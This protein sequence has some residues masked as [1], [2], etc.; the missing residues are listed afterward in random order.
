[1]VTGATVKLEVS[2][3]FIDA[4]RQALLITGDGTFDIR[5]L[6]LILKKLNGKNLSWHLPI[7]RYLYVR[8]G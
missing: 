5:F 4:K 6:K 3:N 2:D 8:E 1:M 7:F